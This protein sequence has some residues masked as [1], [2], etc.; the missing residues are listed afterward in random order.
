M[1]RRSSALA[2]LG[3]FELVVLLAVLHLSQRDETQSY[4]STIVREIAQRTG[5][6][7]SRGAVYVTLDRLQAKGLLASRSGGKTPERGGR[8]RR[9]FRA[10]PAGLA[11][12]KHSVATVARMHAALEPLLGDL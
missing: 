8:P 10:T 2:P 11:A 9:L 12:A 6:D 3:E 4:G 5:R 1:A 7:V